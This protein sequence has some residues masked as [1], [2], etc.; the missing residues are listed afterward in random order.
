MSKIKIVTKENVKRYYKREE[1]RKISMQEDLESFF[2]DIRNKVLLNELQ[3]VIRSFVLAKLNSSEMHLLNINDAKFVW[4]YYNNSFGPIL[5][6]HPIKQ[7]SESKS[8]YSLS[9]SNR[10]TH[11]VT[12]VTNDSYEESDF[13]PCLQ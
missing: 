11:N 13:Q 12:T 3:S 6:P 1:I 2:D 8:R 10:I 5:E 9:F 7:P 4:S